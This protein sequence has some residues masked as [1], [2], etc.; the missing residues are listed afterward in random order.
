MLPRKWAPSAIATRGEIRSP[1]TEPLSRMSTFSEA[2]TLPTTSPRTMTDLANTAALILPFGPIVRTFWRSSILPS[3]WPSMVRSSLPLSSPL[4]TT[5]L[6][7][8]TTSLIGWA[9][10]R[11]G[12]AGA[13]TTGACAAGTPAVGGVAGVVGPCGARTPSSRFHIRVSSKGRQRPAHARAGPSLQRRAVCIGSSRRSNNPGSIR[14]V[15]EV[16]LPV[17]LLRLR[18][19]AI[20]EIG[21]RSTST[22]TPRRQSIRRSRTPWTAPFAR[23]SAT[24]PACTAGASGPRRGSTRARAAVAAPRRRRSDRGHLHRQRHRGRRPGGARRGR[25]A[26][27]VRPA[28]P[29]RQ[30]HRAR[31][32]AA[33]RAG[34]R[35]P[36][37]GGQLARRRSL[38]ASIAPDAL[39]ALVTDRTA[40]VSVMHANNEVGTIQP[41]AELAAIAHARGALFH[42]DAVQAAGKLPLDVAA[43]GVDLLAI[44]GHKFSGP[45]GTGALWVRRG[46][47]LIAQMTGG[48]QER[49]R[50]AGTENVPAL[51]GLGVAADA[52]PDPPRRDRPRRRAARHARARPPR[53]GARHARQ[54]PAATPASPTPANIGF[55]GIE[56]ESLVIAFDLEGVA[57]STGSAC[58]SGTLEPSHVLKAMG[59]DPHDTQNAIRFSLGFVHHRRR[60][61]RA[62]SRSRPALVE[63]LR[64]V[65]AGAASRGRDARARAREADDHARRR[66]DVGRRGFGGRR[67]ADGRSGP[68]RRRRL[69]AALRSAAA[70]GRQP[71]LRLVLL[72]RRSARRAPRRRRP[73]RAALHHELRA[74]VRRARRRSLRRRLH[75]GPH[76]DPVHALQQRSQVLDAAR[77]R[78]R[79]RGRRARHRALRA[80]RL[81]RGPPAATCCA[82]AS[83]AAATSRTSCS[84]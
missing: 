49:N 62:S 34:P 23:T 65:T 22:T 53:R 67:R 74:A 26:R 12:L 36:R 78:R 45:K 7:M 42:T 52:R 50:R 69:D 18:G 13:S 10:G 71:R 48:R 30:H 19:G 37:L 32:G 58:S 35:P 82:A 60:T 43:L 38:A 80:R 72:A 44:S 29:R 47:R 41:I 8:F 21:G 11:D 25:S 84:R 33:D 68:R 1:S 16:C 31:G 83:T 79:A 46:T 56:A 81:R 51:V 75:A 55:E 61:S 57:V 70:R 73:R 39:A 28:A 40:L 63:R 24:P 17:L 66:R 4:M 9:S 5:D 64:A 20:I 15:P 59:L 3:T 27:A 76:A 77:A 6:P 2:V 14:S 54:R